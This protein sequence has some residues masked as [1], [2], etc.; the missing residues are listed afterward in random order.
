MSHL[1]YEGI[2]VL[3]TSGLLSARLIGLLLADQGAKVLVAR[4]EHNALPSSDPLDPTLHFA[5]LDPYLDRGKSLLQTAG[6]QEST[7]ADILIVQGNEP[8]AVKRWQ[9]L[10]RVVAALPGDATYGHLPADCSEDLLSGN[11]R[12]TR[13]SS[14]PTYLMHSRSALITAPK[15]IRSTDG[16]PIR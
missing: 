1:P 4:S 10:V 6:E 9:I 15:Q 12:H 14:L 3:E 2:C 8:V 5:H 13:V 7:T 16:A 11:K